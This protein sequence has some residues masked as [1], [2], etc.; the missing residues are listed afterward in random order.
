MAR[1]NSSLDNIRVAS[2]CSSD[3]NQMRG[4]ERVRFCQ[5]CSLNVYNLSS[6]T[7]REAEQLISNAEGRLCIRYYRRRDGTVLTRNCP[8]GLRALKRRLSGAA[9]AVLSAALGFFAGIGIYAGTAHEEPSL[10]FNTMGQIAMPK[11]SPEKE[12]GGEYVEFVGD[13]GYEEGQVSLPSIKNNKRER[14]ATRKA[15]R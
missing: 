5:Q 6:M 12:E 9:N 14:R 11:E 4:D 10:H 13:Y 1:F 15:P 2:P 3:W 7:R 8:V